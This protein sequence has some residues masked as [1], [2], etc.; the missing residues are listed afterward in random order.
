MFLFMIVYLTL[1]P[2]VMMEVLVDGWILSNGLLPNLLSLEVL[3][4]KDGLLKK[5][6][7]MTMNLFSN[8]PIDS[9]SI[10]YTLDKS[11]TLINS[12]PPLS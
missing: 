3:T 8:T 10:S 6:P 7:M 1:T 9:L 12:I 2:I 5:L 11:N 4:L